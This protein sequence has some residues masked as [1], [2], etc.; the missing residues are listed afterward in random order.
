M[1]E[2]RSGR[3]DP[4]QTM[5]DWGRQWCGGERLT[6]HRPGQDPQE[7]YLPPG[8]QGGGLDGRRFHL[9]DNKEAFD[10][11]VYPIY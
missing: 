3:T 11:E 7:G 1:G 9:G 4:V 6:S 10:A 8:T 5:E 2:G